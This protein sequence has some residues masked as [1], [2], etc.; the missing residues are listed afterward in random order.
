[1]KINWLVVACGLLQAGGAVWFCCN[2]NIRF[3][4][5]YGLYSLTNFILCY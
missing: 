3:G 5:L 2:G 4:M 1:M